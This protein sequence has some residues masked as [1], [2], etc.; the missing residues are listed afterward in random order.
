MTTNLF[1]ISQR[2]LKLLGRRLKSGI[3]LYVQT[4][5]VVLVLF[6]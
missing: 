4:N 2:F 1:K 6:G 3:K 5:V